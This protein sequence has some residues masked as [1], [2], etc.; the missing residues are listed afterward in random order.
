MF[1]DICHKLVA[2]SFHYIF[3]VLLIYF[4]TE[5]HSVIN[6]YLYFVLRYLQFDYRKE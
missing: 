3:I 4:R 5:F 2:Y 6:N 1:L